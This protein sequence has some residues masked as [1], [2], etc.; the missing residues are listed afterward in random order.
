MKKTIVLALA[1]AACAQI[2]GE[3]AEKSQC[4]GMYALGFKAACEDSACIKAKLKNN[5]S[6]IAKKCDLQSVQELDSLYQ[7]YKL[8]QAMAA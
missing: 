8:A 5:Y 2:S 6:A 3:K 4:V 7:D 1:L